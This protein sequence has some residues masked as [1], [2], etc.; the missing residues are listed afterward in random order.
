MLHVSS[1]HGQT[2]RYFDI[3]ERT[4]VLSQK[5][6]TLAWLCY[7]EDSLCLPVSAENCCG[8]QLCV[9]IHVS[10]SCFLA[11]Y[12]VEMKPVPEELVCLWLDKGHRI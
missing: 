8:V 10:P 3:F 9:I 6:K 11:L 2:R 12:T 7:Y 1:F 5:L 4:G